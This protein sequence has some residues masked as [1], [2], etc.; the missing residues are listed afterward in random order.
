MEVKM[1]G[2]SD[3]MME[4]LRDSSAQRDGFSDGVLGVSA[5]G[6]GMSRV[7]VKSSQQEYGWLRLWSLGVEKS[8][9]CGDGSTMARFDEQ[10]FT[11]IVIRYGIPLFPF[12][13]DPVCWCCF[14]DG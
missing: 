14:Q 7:G 2:G 3:G 10:C 6:R 8:Q 9:S 5:G 1:E 13:I 11:A 12:H 4:V